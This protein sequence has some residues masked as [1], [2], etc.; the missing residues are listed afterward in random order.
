M[1]VIRTIVIMVSETIEVQEKIVSYFLRWGAGG[2]E[3]EPLSNYMDAQVVF[4]II[5]WNFD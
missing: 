1:M 2:P 3:P 4:F 5:F